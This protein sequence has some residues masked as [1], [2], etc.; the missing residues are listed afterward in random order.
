[1]YLAPTFYFSCPSILSM[2]TEVFTP[3]WISLIRSRYASTNHIRLKF[4]TAASISKLAESS[5]S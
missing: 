5:A 3:V 4:G 2:K 1:M